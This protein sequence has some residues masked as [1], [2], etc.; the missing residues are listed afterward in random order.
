MNVTRH[1]T[2]P[3]PFGCRWCGEQARNHGRSYVRSRG[4]HG[5]ERPTNDQIK[6]RMRAR[7]ANRKEQ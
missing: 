1:R 5:W 6:A 7:R 3:T 4:M 2:A